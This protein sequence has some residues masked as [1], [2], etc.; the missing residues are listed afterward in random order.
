M[1]TRQLWKQVWDWLTEPSDAI[2][3]PEQHLRA[4]TLA[5]M[6]L[7]SAPIV[8]VGAIYGYRP[9]FTVFVILFPAYLI[10][11][12]RY[13]VVSA[14][15]VLVV[16]TAPSYI[17]VLTKRNFQMEAL[18]FEFAW[19]IIPLLMG[20]VILPSPWPYIFAAAH[21]LGVVIFA[22][23]VPGLGLLEISATLG[24]LVMAAMLMT[25]STYLR[26]QYFRE[27]KQVEEQLR[28]SLEEKEVL[29]KEVYHRVK[30]NLQVIS[31]L[32]RL[33]AGR[34]GDPQAEITL[35]DSRRRV[36][37]IALVHQLLYE[38]QNLSRIDFGLY[39]QN[40]SSQLSYAYEGPVGRTTFRFDTDNILLPV[41]TAV[42]CGLLVTELITNALKH[43]FPGERSGTVY[44]TF[45]GG[46]DGGVRLTV[47]DDGVGFPANLDIYQ[48]DTLGLSLVKGLVRQL[49]GTL[50]LDQDHGTSI[51]VLFSVPGANV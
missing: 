27:R 38:S 11:R 51:T 8:L 35:Q 44:V 29:L 5:G 20:S 40:I 18:G 34:V 28:E 46:E 31:S 16:L 14:L 26:G 39:L 32:L 41:D 3:D 36:E 2:R 22:A 4:R 6:L 24:L 23:V 30:N 13:F 48:A 10:S 45:T 25:L 50:E 42:P 37:S 15:L 21:L 49:D 17:Q 12:T 19:T 7:F 33:Q 43:A 47:R 1:V 9:L